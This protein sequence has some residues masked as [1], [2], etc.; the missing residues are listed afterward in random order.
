MHCH[1]CDRLLKP[2]EIKFN[3]DHDKWDPCSTCIEI[4]ESLFNDDDEEEIEKQL[5]LEFWYE[6]REV[7]G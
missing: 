1:I 2:E 5:A 4:S 3:K 7:G 6:D